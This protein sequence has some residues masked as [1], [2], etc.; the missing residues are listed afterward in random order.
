[1]ALTDNL[2][3]YWKLDETSWNASDSVWSN[4]LTNTSVTYSSWKINN[5]AVFNWS[6]KLEKS[7][8]SSLEPTSA[9]TYWFW[10]KVN[11][12]SVNHGFLVKNHSTTWASPYISYWVRMITTKSMDTFISL[13]G[14]LI[15]YGVSDPIWYSAWTRYFY[16]FTYDWSY[17]RTYINWTKREETSRT[18]SI[19]YNWWSLNLWTDLWWD[20]VQ[21]WVDEAFIYSRAI[22]ST[23]VT[24][25]YNSW[26]GLQYPF[27]TTNIKSI[28]WLTYANFKSMNWL[29]KA[30]I[31][32]INW[33]A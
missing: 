32:N 4:T 3:S 14:A 10:F 5:W 20:S 16:V 21:G 18:W 28:N 11:N 33:L 23:E 25:L 1:M 12:F 17:T 13:W 26:N 22:S 8:T 9:L 19:A 29:A 24:E 6:A 31:K 30:S 7:S 27:T 15:E 2:I